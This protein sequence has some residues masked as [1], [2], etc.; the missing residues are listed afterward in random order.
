MHCMKQ[1][2]QIVWFFKTLV[3]FVKP[4]VTVILYMFIYF[5]SRC[6][7]TRDKVHHFRRSDATDSIQI[8]YWLRTARAIGNVTNIASK[9]TNG[10]RIS[11]LSVVN[12]HCSTLLEYDNMEK[13]TLPKVSSEFVRSFCQDN[14][15]T[16]ERV[17]AAAG[18]SKIKDIND[19]LK[20]F[21]LSQMTRAGGGNKEYAMEFFRRLLVKVAQFDIQER[22]ASLLSQWATS[23]CAPSHD[24]SLLLKLLGICC[25]FVFC[26]S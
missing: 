2:R 12:L 4:Y 13:L 15:N 6:S 18:K 23:I 5:L 16:L 7:E 17:V 25:L 21:G 22:G 3:C 24:F 19:A 8:H 10:L 1:P 9:R 14:P 26:F 11:A 20:S